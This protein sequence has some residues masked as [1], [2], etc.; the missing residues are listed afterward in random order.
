MNSLADKAGLVSGLRLIEVNGE[1]LL[2]CNQ[3]EAKELLTASDD[4]RLLV[5][6][7]YNLTKK[8]PSVSGFSGSRR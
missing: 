3:S 4:L 2:G 1:S 5:C 8:A 7:G 6:D